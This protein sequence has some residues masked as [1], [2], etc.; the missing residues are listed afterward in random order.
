[1][2]TFRRTRPTRDPRQAVHDGTERGVYL[3]AEH[4]KGVA[5]QSAPVDE[6]TLRNS[7]AVT[8]DGTQAIVSFDTPYAARQHEELTWHH[9][10]GGGAKY[11][12]RPMVTEQP[13]IRAIVTQAIR[14]NLV[15]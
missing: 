6:S 4:L 1:M 10:R 12:E 2:A 5:Q 7:A 14:T 11:L 8:H 3:A 13:V 15:Q 9:P